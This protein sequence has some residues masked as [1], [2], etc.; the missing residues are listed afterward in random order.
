M[1][2]K[3]LIK[4]IIII[5]VPIYIIFGL[6]YF[7]SFVAKVMHFKYLFSY[8][9]DY[10]TKLVYEDFDFYTKD[11]SK[12]Y[13]LDYKYFTLYSIQIVDENEK[14]PDMINGEHY[15]FK[16]KLKLDY[17]SGNQL[18]LTEYIEKWERGF[19][20]KV[21]TNFLYAYE[22]KNFTIPIANQYKD[23]SIT[24]TV[25]EPMQYYSPEN[26]LKLSIGATLKE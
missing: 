25:I 20:S 11:Y 15:Q 8:P 7:P 4:K 26:K 21:S 2:K 3:S 18:I 23:L 12:T 5:L 6:G 19:F 1:N 10:F 16:G 17:F 22:L 24:L 9:G 13:K 14:L